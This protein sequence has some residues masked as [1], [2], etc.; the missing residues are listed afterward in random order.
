MTA[1]R[2]PGPLAQSSGPTLGRPTLTSSTRDSA[3]GLQVL[4]RALLELGARR[5]H[6][7]HPWL[8]CGTRTDALAGWRDSSRGLGDAPSRWERLSCLL[9]AITVSAPPASAEATPKTTVDIPGRLR[10]WP[11]WCWSE[12]VGCTDR[13][14][15]AV[16]GP[17]VRGR[18]QGR[19]RAS[20]LP[21]LVAALCGARDW[22]PGSQPGPAGPRRRA[23]WEQLLERVRPPSPGLSS[24]Q[25]GSRFQGRRR[26]KGPL[27]GCRA[28]GA[29]PRPG[30]SAVESPSERPSPDLGSG[31]EHTAELPVSAA[32]RGAEFAQPR[33]APWRHPGCT[34]MC[35]RGPEG[36]SGRPGP[37]AAAHSTAALFPSLAP[38]QLGE[39]RAPSGSVV[40][41]RW[42]GCCREAGVAP[43]D[44]DD[45]KWSQQALSGIW[46]LTARGVGHRR[47]QERLDT[48]GVRLPGRSSETGLQTLHAIRRGAVTVW[49]EAP[50]SLR[51]PASCRLRPR[52]TSTRV[53]TWGLAPEKENTA[54]VTGCRFQDDG[55][56][57]L[58][59]L[60]GLPAGLI[61]LKPVAVMG[62]PS[63]EGTEAYQQP[64]V[65]SGGDGLPMSL[66]MRLQPVKSL[67]ALRTDLE[68]Q[69]P[70]GPAP[71]SLTHRSE[72]AGTGEARVVWGRR[73]SCPVAGGRG[74]DPSVTRR[75]SPSGPA[76]AR[77]EPSATG[78]QSVPRGPAA[79][80]RLG[81]RADLVREEPGTDAAGLLLRPGVRGA[82]TAAPRGAGRAASI[83]AGSVPAR[84]RPQPQRRPPPRT[85][86][87]PAGATLA[88]GAGRS[89]LVARTRREGPVSAAPRPLRSLGGSAAPADP[90]AA[91]PTPAQ[92]TTAASGRRGPGRARAWAGASERGDRGPWSPV[93]VRR[94][95]LAGSELCRGAS[96]RKT[97]RGWGVRSSPPARLPALRPRLGRHRLPPRAPE[98]TRTPDLTPRFLSD[99][100]PGNSSSGGSGTRLATRVSRGNKVLSF[101]A[102]CQTPGTLLQHLRDTDSGVS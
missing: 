35:S 73:R 52:V 17:A 32:P 49:Q 60:S 72:D 66:K 42:E 74:W 69:A 65:A 3:A 89:P 36:P 7:V 4:A 91:A 59:F 58:W 8:E 45:G 43:H 86:P 71:V 23:R 54:A 19:Y 76:G 83:P 40:R 29:E 37:T 28:P 82:D 70:R 63:D 97:W 64:R 44:G 88:R 95:P 14:G 18:C 92:A 38:G 62:R 53:C 101:S 6:G 21:P 22:P 102:T 10:P 79:R 81:S 2:D 68:P 75:G 57:R 61:A 34:P 93:S 87:R 30:P 100:A 98:G 11:G 9:R 85:P 15:A 31:S 46:S 27:A 51:A 24:S 94:E 78:T 77:T 56:G 13:T 80:Q 26:A 5:G 33:S 90:P 84:G 16:G 41:R 39:D 55:T 96:A 50:R 67:E 99:L 47:P 20:R 12:R 25:G 1:R 48:T